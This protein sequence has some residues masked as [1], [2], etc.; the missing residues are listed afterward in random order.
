[1]HHRPWTLPTPWLAAALAA[2]LLA[3][4]GGGSR[5][6]AT[7]T[8]GDDSATLDW[9]SSALIDVLANDSA[10]R[11]ALSL[12]AVE[13]PAHG[14]AVI[15][16]GQ[17]RY[18]PADG[19]FGRDSVRYSVQAEA[20][21]AT[22]MA[23]L[24]VTVQARLMLSGTI[25]DAP[26]ADA[27]VRLQVG[28]QPLDLAADAQGRYTAEVLS[29]DPASWVQVSGVSPDGRVRLVSVVGEL[30][31]VAALADADTGEVGAAELPALDATH[32]TSAE[33]ALRAR[34][35]GGKLPASAADM[36]ASDG[37]V[38]A[39]ELQSLAIAVRLIAD[40]GVALPAGVDDSFALLLDRSAAQ[41]FVSAQAVA[42]PDGF[43][44]AR[45]AVLETAP[46]PAGDV[47]ALTEARTLVYS[48]GG[49]PA[50]SIDL[51]LAL[52]PDGEA[53]VHSQQGVLPA[54][55]TAAGAV[56]DVVLTAP[57]EQTGVQCMNDPTTG[58]CTQ[59]T[60]AYQTLAYRLKAVG[61]GS[62]NKQ[63]VLLATRY[64]NLWLDGPKAGE[65][66]VESDG[67]IGFLVTLFDLAGRAGVAADELVAGARLAGVRS[68]DMAPDT[69]L[70]REDILH[71][72]GP[73]TARFEISGKAATW[74]LEDGWLTVRAA[75]VAA[76]RYTR[77]E[78][79]PLTGLESWIGSSVP[80]AAADAIQYTMEQELLFVDAD[81]AFTADSA[82]RR[83]RS[84]GFVVAS[85]ETYGL[86]PS[87][88]LNPDGSATGIV[89]R[90][91]VAADGTLEL[92][93]VYQGADYIRRWVPL[94]RVGDN[95]VVLEI[96]DW[97]YIE[98]G[99]MAWRI[100]WQ[101][102]LGPAGS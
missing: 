42:D 33:A 45:Q 16:D 1:M 27:A 34:A 52:R 30:G 54:T 87:Y 2:S 64:R 95:L 75:G 66:I 26:I 19:W 28:E 9:R 46:P 69:G 20:G 93:R 12:V 18:T 59:Y 84:E 61:G 14:T 7:V 31:D 51:T 43:A 29:A 23:T 13:A 71:I 57:Q 21:G 63:P 25:T 82:A 85:P 24:V 67:G 76:S 97:G 102:D 39:L 36:V 77:L 47:W 10:S 99:L 6:D 53:S 22:A 68:E 32:W 92:I 38:Q 86:E 4:C 15:E 94:R 40:G 11:G 49:N 88:V 41:A 5:P 8:A 70:T 17:L 79:D 3:A 73:G 90:W 98:P 101:V 80:G 62:A 50:S 89:Q 58:V 44:A 91:Q 81:P 72:D 100:N 83:W 56:L 35:L 65:V 78:R 48:D 55:W 60:V 96:I 74:S 37:A